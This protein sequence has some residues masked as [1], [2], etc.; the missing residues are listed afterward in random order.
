MHRPVGGSGPTL[1]VT[2][3]TCSPYPGGAPAACGTG[4]GPTCGL[5]CSAS[6]GCRVLPTKAPPP[7]C[8]AD[9]RSARSRA[10][11]RHQSLDRR[12]EPRPT[13]H[14]PSF[15]EAAHSARHT[16]PDAR[17]GHLGAVRRRGSRAGGGSPEQVALDGERTVVRL[18]PRRPERKRWARPGA[19]AWPRR[20]QCQLLITEGPTAARLPR[21]PDDT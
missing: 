2:A 5:S 4:G 18:V 20:E 9:L 8:C 6:G 10:R 21:A 19:G 11:R 1:G 7:G 17:K 12:L 13:T 16:H 15:P 14:A 3:S